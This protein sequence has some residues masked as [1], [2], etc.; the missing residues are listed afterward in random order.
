[1]G[2]WNEDS[3]DNASKGNGGVIEGGLIINDGN[4]ITKR[5]Q[6]YPDGYG[7]YNYEYENYSVK[8]AFNNYSAMVTDSK[9]K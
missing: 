1:M 9:E 5:I 6:N 2:N 3:F 4:F 7:I 8:N